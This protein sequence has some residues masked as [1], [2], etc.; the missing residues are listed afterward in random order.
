MVRYF[1]RIAIALSILINTCLGGK[2]NQ[3]FSARNWQWKRD[4]KPNL[5]YIIDKIFFLKRSHCLDSWTKWT[6]INNSIARYNE[7]MGYSPR[8][9]MYFN[10]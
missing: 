9:K 6:I 3:T 2:N 7:G 10:E 8:R 4:N 5:V 1:K